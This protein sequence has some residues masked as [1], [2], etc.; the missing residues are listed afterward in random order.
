[1]CASK[2]W[3][4]SSVCKKSRAQHP[5]RAE[6]QSLEKSPLGCKFIRVNN[7][8]VCGPKYAKFFSPNVGGV[9]DDEELFRFLI[10]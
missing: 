5:L 2:P 4:I 1:V 9:V 3:L 8:S 6:I 10:C 7:F